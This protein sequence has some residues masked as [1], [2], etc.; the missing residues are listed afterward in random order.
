VRT[1]GRASCVYAAALAVS[2]G[3]GCASGPKEPVETSLRPTW[4]P[5]KMEC[6]P[7]A[8]EVMKRMGLSVGDRIPV[9]VDETQNRPGSA[10]YKSRFVMSQPKV[11]QG[12]LKDISIAGYLYVANHRVFGRY[13]RAYVRQYEGGKVRDFYEVPFCGVLLDPRWDKD[14]EGLI[15]YLGPEQGTAVVQDSRGVIQVVERFP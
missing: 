4:M 15:S 1:A 3:A 8:V 6:P 12:E 7:D 5:P 11:E 10:H 14:G 13:D 9:V 2:L